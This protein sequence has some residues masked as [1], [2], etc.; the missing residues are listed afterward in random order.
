[1]SFWRYKLLEL[2][3]GFATFPVAVISFIAWLWVFGQ[4]ADP[5]ASGI[6]FFAFAIP[7]LVVWIWFTNRITKRFEQRWIS[8][9]Q[10][11]AGTN[12]KVMGR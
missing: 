6:A 9:H 4:F 11:D 5:T 7:F 2:V 8:R 3:V 10:N 12:S 1:V